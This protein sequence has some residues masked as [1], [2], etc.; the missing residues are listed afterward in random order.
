M[1]YRQ[2]EQLFKASALVSVIAYEFNRRH[3]ILKAIM[4]RDG[5]GA[6]DSKTS[7]DPGHN[8]IHGA[9]EK[10]VSASRFKSVSKALLGTQ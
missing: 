2:Y 10:G 6:G 3:P 7:D 1:K 8:V 4:P 5:S 9:G